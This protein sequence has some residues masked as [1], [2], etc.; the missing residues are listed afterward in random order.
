MIQRLHFSDSLDLNNNSLLHIPHGLPNTLTL[1]NLGNNRIGEWSDKDL[2]SLLNL[3]ALVSLNLEDNNIKV[4]YSW[5][6]DGLDSLKWIGLAG[7]QLVMH[8]S[9][10]SNYISS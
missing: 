3:T 4:L 9:F 5:Q 2:D 7:N 1:L 8:D 10:R 6:F